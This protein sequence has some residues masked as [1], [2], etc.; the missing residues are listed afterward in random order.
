[1]ALYTITLRELCETFGRDYVESI[2][3]R[4]NIEDFLTQDEIDVINQRGTWNKDKLARKIVDHYYMHEIG[5]ETPAL[6]EHYVKVAM[7]EIM[8]EKLPI[9][10]SIS[11]A[12]DPLV[13]VDFTE[14]YR[15]N[16]KSDATSNG[17]GIS[18]NSDTPQGKITKTDILSGK[19]VSQTSGSESTTSGTS[20]DQ[21]QYT[22]SVKGNSGVSATAQKMIQ[23]Y[24]DNIIMVDRD[25]INDLG[26]LFHGMMMV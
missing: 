10:Y 1:M 20:Q 24:R 2:F 17:N 19:Y 14:E 3:K 4:Y 26:S 7:Q 5:Q 22:K 18:L 6:F 12:Y 16:S 23:Q 13:N 9:I 8:E 25:I 11:I 21:N 15:G